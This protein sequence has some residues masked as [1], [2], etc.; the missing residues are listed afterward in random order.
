MQDKASGTEEVQSQEQH[1]PQQQQEGKGST[2][3]AQMRSSQQ[4]SDAGPK[5]SGSSSWAQVVMHAA[6]PDAL[7]EQVSS[8]TLYAL[9]G[10]IML[11]LET[12]PSPVQCY[13][14][15]QLSGL[16]QRRA[17]PATHPE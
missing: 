3:G 5:S 14:A 7:R 11:H 13:A 4:E 1:P 2:G 16:P 17:Q 6:A 9:M 12:S 10:C 15:L 8:K